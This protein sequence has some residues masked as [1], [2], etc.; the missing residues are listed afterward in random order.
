M[1]TTLYRNR[2]VFAG[3]TL[4]VACFAEM[5]HGAEPSKNDVYSARLGARYR[6]ATVRGTSFMILVAVD[7][8]SPLRALP[9]DL[10]RFDV[11]MTMDGAGLDGPAAVESHYAA[12]PMTLVSTADHAVRRCTINLPPLAGQVEAPRRLLG[13]WGETTALPIISENGPA[14]YPGLRIT[15]IVANSPAHRAG[16]E[17]GMMIAQINDVRVYTMDGVREA[18]ADSGPVASVLLYTSD[19]DSCWV[20]VEIGG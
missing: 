7:A 17:N 16:F 15:G 6:I 10:K 12:T 2:W 8:N 18:I 14:G 4:L 3:L 19:G 1:F 5:V 11:I 13:V 9:V 20:D